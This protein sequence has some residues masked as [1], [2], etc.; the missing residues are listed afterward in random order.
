MSRPPVCVD[1]LD[2]LVL[3]VR[4]LEGTCAFY[5]AVLGMRRET[6]GAGRIALRFGHQKIN[7]HPDP[8]PHALVADRPVPGSADLCFLTATPAAEVAAHLDACGIEVIGGPLERNGA[9]GPTTLESMSRMIFVG[10]RRS[11]KRSIHCPERSASA[12]RFS[13]V[14][15]TSVSKRPI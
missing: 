9:E 2:H 8:S 13:S 12:A 7:L 3:T 5:E 10:G 6:F 11:C 1:A 14:A 15:R 4:D